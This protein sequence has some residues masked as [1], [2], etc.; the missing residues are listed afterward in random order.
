MAGPDLIAKLGGIPVERIRLNPPPGTATEADLLRRM[1][2]P[3]AWIS[4]LIDGVVV[5]KALS[6]HKSARAGR[7]LWGIG[8][9]VH[10]NDLGVMPGGR[11]PFRFP[12]GRV[13]IPDLCYIPWERIPGE[14]VPDEEVSGLVP[15][16]T[17]D[18]FGPGNTEAEIELKVGDYFAAGVRLAWVI[19]YE[20]E[21]ARLI[22]RSGRV[23]EIGRDE[24]LDGED[25]LPGLAIPLSDVLDV[26]IRKKRK[27]R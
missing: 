21:R 20:R 25:V 17:A 3:D 13:R 9:H 1:Q 27:P 19:D 6:I 5:D 4:E 22:S 14:E 18:M 23:R 10:A 26:F 16:L 2:G 7:L 11:V 15:D 24:S 8:N 12:P